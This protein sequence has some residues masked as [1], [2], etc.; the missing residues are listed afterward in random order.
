MAKPQA[1]NR[2]PGVRAG[3][4]DDVGN[5]VEIL[6]DSFADDPMLNWVIPRRELYADYFALLVREV[7][8]PRGLVHVDRHSRATALWLPPEQRLERAPLPALLRLGLRLLASEGLE[9]LWRLRQQGRVY[10]RHLPREPHYYL[11]FIGCRRDSQGRGIGTTV[12]EHGTAVCDAHGMPAY[13]ESSHA[14]N[15]PLYER[16]GFEVRAQE[17]LAPGGP[18]VWFMWREPR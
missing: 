5:L 7:Y 16:L 2:P 6:C 15:V 13:L 9:P 14:R 1:D 18:T 4:K 11:Q 12:L 17:A 10:A 3:T 8:L